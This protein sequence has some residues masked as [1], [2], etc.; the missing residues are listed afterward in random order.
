MQYPMS[1]WS[2]LHARGRHP[3]LAF[4]GRGN[5]GFANG[6]F[7]KRRFLQIQVPNLQIQIGNLQ[8]QI[9]H[10]QIQSGKSANPNREICRS[11]LGDMLTLCLIAKQYEEICRFKSENLQIQIKHLQIQIRKSA[12]PNRKPANPNRKYVNPNMKSANPNCALQR[13]IPGPGFSRTRV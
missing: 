4:Q 10:L 8:I 1:C 12:N 6:G 13:F 7:E 3:S 5:Q 2:S 9:G 11:K